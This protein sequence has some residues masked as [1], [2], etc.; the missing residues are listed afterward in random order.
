MSKEVESVMDRSVAILF[1]QGEIYIIFLQ[2]T[3]SDPVAP[4]LLD[5]VN[6]HVRQRAN[7]PATVST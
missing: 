3:V 1:V 2:V 5:S 7:D 6:H 4:K